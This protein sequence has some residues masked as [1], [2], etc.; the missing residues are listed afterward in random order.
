VVS[1]RPP[2]GSLSSVLQTLNSMASQMSADAIT[3]ATING[4]ARVLE[5]GSDEETFFRDK[6]LDAH[7]SS[8]GGGN[9]YFSG[10]NARVVVVEIR[11]VRISDG[12]GSARVFAIQPEANG[13]T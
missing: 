3:S 5:P 6:Q 2:G 4:S 12:E 10:E 13:R 7:G 1:I 11:D 9:G 8:G